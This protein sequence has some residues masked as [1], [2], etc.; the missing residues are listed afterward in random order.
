M[1][2]R[3][4]LTA[5]LAS[6]GPAEAYDWPACAR[7]R[8]A[9]KPVPVPFEVEEGGKVSPARVGLGN[10]PNPCVE[11]FPPV[12]VEESSNHFLKNIPKSTGSGIHELL[13]S[14]VVFQR[15]MPPQ[16]H[17]TL[18]F[19]KIPYNPLLSKGKS[20]YQISKP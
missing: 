16:Y 7:K 10:F 15:Q 9:A 3:R 11:I 14:F 6:G 13:H 12:C 17:K 4:A 2:P 20:L 18:E 5:V 19:H 8:R 1:D